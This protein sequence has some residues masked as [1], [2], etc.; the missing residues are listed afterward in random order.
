METR[1]QVFL[2]S[3]Y[4]DLR[5]ERTRVIQALLELDCIPSGMEHFPATDEEQF[6]FIKRV[7]DVCDYYVV[8]IGG[9]ME[10]LQRKVSPIQ[11]GNMHMLW[12]RTSQY[13]GFC[14]QNLK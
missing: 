1:F 3:T 10:H 12:I 7:I 8:I 14:M 13:V 4:A 6:E 2:S 5:E 9:D 11:K